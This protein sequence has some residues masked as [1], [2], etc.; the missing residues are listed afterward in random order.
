[1]WHFSCICFGR[2]LNLTVSLWL[3]RL[4]FLSKATVHVYN[5]HFFKFLFLIPFF[6]HLNLLV[7]SALLC[8]PFLPIPEYT[9]F[10]RLHIKGSTHSYKAVINADYIQ[11]VSRCTIF[12]C[13]TIFKLRKS[14]FSS[15]LVKEVK[16]R[17][18]EISQKLISY[19]WEC[20]ENTGN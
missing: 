10:N 19:F 20:I 8:C 12:T 9:R 4:F 15:F 3:Q 5:H 14:G 2:S 13:V 17:Q 1:M 16:F 7:T 6:S 11:N 18:I